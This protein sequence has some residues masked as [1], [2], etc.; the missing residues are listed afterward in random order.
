MICVFPLVPNSELQILICSRILSV[1][2]YAINITIH[3][4]GYIVYLSRSG[5]RHLAIG[6]RTYLGYNRCK[7]EQLLI[8]LRESAM[9]SYNR[10]RAQFHSILT[11]YYGF[12]QLGRRKILDSERLRWVMG[13]MTYI[14]HLLYY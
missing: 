14:F 7:S 4:P 3:G 13:F 1:E 10:W 2:G 12:L 5:Q 11:N 9:Q 8:V 6:P